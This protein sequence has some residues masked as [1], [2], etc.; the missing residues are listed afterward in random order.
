MLR[1]NYMY[2]GGLDWNDDI[3]GDNNR[4][5]KS[6]QHWGNAPAAV[7]TKDGNIGTHVLAA[8][9]VFYSGGKSFGWDSLTTR[10]QINHPRRVS[11][12]NSPLPDY[13]NVL[14]GDLRVKGHGQEAYTY[15]LNTATDSTANWAVVMDNNNNGQSGLGGFFYWSEGDSRVATVLPARAPARA[16]PEVQVRSR[17][18]RR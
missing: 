10:Y 4:L 2:V 7:F 3:G 12:V 18:C 9:M 11:A 17:S 15:P 16:T 14:Y 6:R 13:Q 1:S 5:L 8:D